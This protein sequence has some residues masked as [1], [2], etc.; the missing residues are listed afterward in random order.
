MMYWVFRQNLTSSRVLHRICRLM[1]M[2]ILCLWIQIAGAATAP[3]PN[4]DGIIS[5]RCLVLGAGKPGGEVTATI[6][7]ELNNRGCLREIDAARV[8][9]VSTL[10]GFEFAPRSNPQRPVC[11]S[12]YSNAP[13]IQAVPNNSMKVKIYEYLRIP[14][15]GDIGAV[16]DILIKVN[17]K[18]E[19]DS[20]KPDGFMKT[21]MQLGFV[22][23]EPIAKNA[24][25]TV[26]RMSPQALGLMADLTSVAPD[27]FFVITDTKGKITFTLSFDATAIA[28]LQGIDGFE[29][30]VKLTSNPLKLEIVPDLTIKLG[31][32]PPSYYGY[33]FQN[34]LTAKLENSR[35]I[36][37][38]GG[39]KLGQDDSGNDI[40]V[41]FSNLKIQTNCERTCAQ[42]Q[43]DIAQSV[44]FMKYGLE[45]TPKKIYGQASIADPDTSSNGRDF[46]VSIS[47][48]LGLKIQSAQNPVSYNC[49]NVDLSFNSN[50]EL[51]STINLEPLSADRTMLVGCDMKMDWIRGRLSLEK[52]MLY[53]ENGE[54]R[55][56][57]TGFWS[58][59]YLELFESNKEVSFVDMNW[60][61]QNGVFQFESVPEVKSSAPLLALGSLILRFAGNPEFSVSAAGVRTLALKCA[62]L[63]TPATSFNLTGFNAGDSCLTVSDADNEPSFPTTLRATISTGLFTFIDLPVMFVSQAIPAGTPSSRSSAPAIPAFSLKISGN[64]GT[65]KKSGHTLSGIFFIPLAKADAKLAYGGKIWTNNPNDRIDGLELIQASAANVGF[66]LVAHPN[67]EGL[68]KIDYAEATGNLE[69]DQDVKN[70]LS[71]DWGITTPP[72]SGTFRVAVT[73]SGNTVKITGKSM[74]LLADLSRFTIGATGPGG[75]LAIISSGPSSV[76]SATLDGTSSQIY[77]LTG[78]IAVGA[79]LSSIASISTNVM[80]VKIVFGKNS[81]SGK[82]QFRVEVSATAAPIQIPYSLLFNSFSSTV[83]TKQMLFGSG[84]RPGAGDQETIMNLLGALNT[85]TGN[86]SGISVNQLMVQS[87]VWAGAVSVGSIDGANWVILPPNAAPKKIQ[88]G[89]IHFLQNSTGS[90][91]YSV[92]VGQNVVM[93]DASALISVAGTTQSFALIHNGSNNTW[94]FL[95]LQGLDVAPLVATDSEEYIKGKYAGLGLPPGYAAMMKY[96]NKTVIDKFGMSVWPNRVAY[97]PGKHCGIWAFTGNDA[98]AKGY[99]VLNP[100]ADPKNPDGQNRPLPAEVTDQDSTYWTQITRVNAMGKKDVGPFLYSNGWLKKNPEVDPSYTTESFPESAMESGKSLPQR[101]YEYWDNEDKKY[102]SGGAMQK[103][104]SDQTFCNMFTASLGYEYLGNVNITAGLNANGAYDAFFK[105]ATNVP[106]A[107]LLPIE[108]SLRDKLVAAGVTLTATKDYKAAVAEARK[109]KMV[110][111]VY[112]NTTTDAGGGNPGSGHLTV[113]TGAYFSGTPIYGASLNPAPSG[114]ESLRNMALL[115]AG[116]SAPAI[117]PFVLV[118]GSKVDYGSNVKE[119]LQF[120]DTTSIHFFIFTKN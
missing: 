37:F 50:G 96:M 71:I 85:A 73:G 28:G 87:N 48:R 94:F 29:A 81:Q 77:T 105:I 95:S 19:L 24:S 4:P 35:V 111:I 108:K 41:A 83:S 58:Y 106:D 113:V 55:L 63:T 114:E 14:S 39:F 1:G 52:K 89:K 86:T 54:W 112:K 120:P 62:Q 5:Q 61:S 97:N 67:F 66:S 18:V 32:T 109:G 40:N 64:S 17:F 118:F 98:H 42:M 20:G 76:D 6:G 33:A 107:N 99:L 91:T 23:D 7:A 25:G 47:G 88:S 74:N 44:S 84:I 93:Q 45:M 78:S 116:A 60:K 59:K 70:S 27:S 75:S 72:L 92:L 31:S 12:T 90:V 3:K 51:N 22:P 38:K 26:P 10:Y 69:F 2:S 65:L 68:I 57:G 104:C 110:I 16:E 11:D 43:S 8:D 82:G 115:N 21:A 30:K 46:Y 13:C 102:Q 56:I 100:S 53:R 9:Q 101:R 34:T 103:V 117:L 49:E 15:G 79:N 36:T 80:P 119:T